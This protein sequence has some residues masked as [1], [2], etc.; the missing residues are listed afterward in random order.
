MSK[1]KKNGKK[2]TS[3][4]SQITIIKMV[5]KS[6]AQHRTTAHKGLLTKQQGHFLMTGGHAQS[7]WIFLTMP[8]KRLAATTYSVKNA[9]RKQRLA[10]CVTDAS[11]ANFNQ[12][13]RSGVLSTNCL[14][15]ARTKVVVKSRAKV[16]LNSISEFVPSL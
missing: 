15:L 2:E 4:K 13:S 8:L 11:M 1:S 3:V 16:S 12:T 9:S 5:Q 14:S 10:H 6:Y 7:V